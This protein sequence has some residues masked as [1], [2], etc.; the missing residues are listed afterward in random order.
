MGRQLLADRH[1]AHR[2]TVAVSRDG[3]QLFAFGFKQHAVQVVTH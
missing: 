2:Q 3:A 1:R